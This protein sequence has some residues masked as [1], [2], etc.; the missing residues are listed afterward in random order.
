M[1]DETIGGGTI[2]PSNCKIRGQEM[3]RSILEVEIP[4][5]IYKFLLRRKCPDE[6]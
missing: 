5:R 6:K 2:Y 4:G 1:N 3:P